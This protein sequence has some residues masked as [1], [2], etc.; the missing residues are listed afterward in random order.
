[1]ALSI[2]IYNSNGG[3]V[4]CFQ[5]SFVA[6]KIQPKLRYCIFSGIFDLNLPIQWLLILGCSLNLDIT[7]T[8]LNVLCYTHPSLYRRLECIFTKKVKYL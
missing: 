7:F 8:N 6:I 1:M 3:I 5:Y 4:I 2:K